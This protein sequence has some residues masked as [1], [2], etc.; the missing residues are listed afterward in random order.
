MFLTNSCYV[1]IPHSAVNGYFLCSLSYCVIHSGK[2][3]VV[4]CNLLQNDAVNHLLAHLPESEKTPGNITALQTKVSPENA[5]A[6]VSLLKSPLFKQLRS[7][8]LL[9]SENTDAACFQKLIP[10]LHSVV[11]LDLI[12]CNIETQSAKYLAEFLHSNSIL[13]YLALTENPLV[14]EDVVL[15][16][17]ALINNDTLLVLAIDGSL[18]K[19][20]QV[21]DATQKINSIR[22][23]HKARPLGFDCFE[24]MRFST[25]WSKMTS[26]IVSAAST[27]QKVLG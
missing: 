17:K 11:L 12:D 21:K 27:V 18:Q 4:Q 13:E 10:V 20:A 7:L 22:K 6:F 3:W 8:D 15:M 2:K 16:V 14:I 23:E 25:V 9:H 1:E 19:A 5:E 24:T 26:V